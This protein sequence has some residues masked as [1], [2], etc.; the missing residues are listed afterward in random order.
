MVTVGGGNGHPVQGFIVH[1]APLCFYSRFFEAACNG[2]WT[3]AENGHVNLPNDSPAVFEVLVQWLYTQRIA[4]A[5]YHNHETTMVMLVRLYVLADKLGILELKNMSI[6]AFVEDGET[7]YVL[8]K[9]PIIQEVWKTTMP[10]SPLRQVCVD[11]WSWDSAP[12]NFDFQEAAGDL[13][14][15]L[16]RVAKILATRVSLAP[17][18]APFRTNM[19]QYH[20]PAF[21]AFCSCGKKRD[22]RSEQDSGP[23][24]A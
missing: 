2:R 23:S 21:G 22:E 7:R 14:D 11:L 12:C 13:G 20:E 8:P 18:E 3:E 16:Y 9:E 15:F 24:S 17:A 5:I 6:D 19:C 4:A 1:K 10:G